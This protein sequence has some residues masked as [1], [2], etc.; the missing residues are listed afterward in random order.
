MPKAIRNALPVKPISLLKC[1]SCITSSEKALLK[2]T[3]SRSLNQTPATKLKPPA[4]PLLILC[5][6]IVNAAGPTE[7]ISNKLI[8]KPFTKASNIYSKTKYEK[9]WQ[10]KLKLN[11]DLSS[12]E[13]RNGA[14]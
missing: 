3:Q 2:I 14:A 7:K 4:L 8:A 6:M 13:Y 11:A 9:I 12:F 10:V 1:S 5:L